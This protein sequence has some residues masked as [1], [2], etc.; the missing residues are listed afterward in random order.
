MPL[1]IYKIKNIDIMPSL[2]VQRNKEVKVF[3]TE[4]I[5]DAA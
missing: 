4:N 2:T 5:F 1:H 3:N